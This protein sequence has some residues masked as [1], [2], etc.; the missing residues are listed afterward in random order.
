[1]RC[2]TRMLI[3][4]DGTATCGRP[5]CIAPM[6]RLPDVTA[7]HRLVASCLLV[8]GLR[9]PHC[10]APAGRHRACP[11]M[12]TVH[13]DRSFECSGAHCPT[14]LPRATWLALHDRFEAC[15]PDAVATCP[16]CATV[17]AVSTGS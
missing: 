10:A 9:C 14:R 1:M 2:P 3:H 17:P 8:Y 12:V 4:E 11:G 7:R 15:G 16:L 13:A 6:D 5:G